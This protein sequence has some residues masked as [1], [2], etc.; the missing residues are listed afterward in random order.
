MQTNTLRS[1]KLYQA[2]P[3]DSWQHGQLRSFPETS[4]EI[5]VFGSDLRV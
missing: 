5:A 1:K 3:K 4:V 2:F